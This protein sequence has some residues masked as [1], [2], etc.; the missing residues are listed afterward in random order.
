MNQNEIL[1][2]SS[3]VLDEA[4]DQ[5]KLP[6]TDCIERLGKRDLK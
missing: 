2:M 4:F 6:R 3:R 1:G 5:G